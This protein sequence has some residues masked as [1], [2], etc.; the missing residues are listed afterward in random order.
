ME[1]TEQN[2]KEWKA[3]VNRLMERYGTFFSWTDCLE[4]DDW[5]KD[6]EGFT[7]EEYVSEEIA[8]WEP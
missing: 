4:D 3:E 1:L 5:I 8:Q 2:I 6:W 7:P